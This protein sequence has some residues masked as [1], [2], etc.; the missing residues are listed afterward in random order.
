MK[1]RT[2]RKI[3]G[4]KKQQLGGVLGED[5]LKKLNLLYPPYRSAYTTIFNG[6]EEELIKELVAYGFTGET[7][8]TEIEDR[9]NEVAEELMK[10][11]N[12]P[13]NEK[14]KK[15]TSSELFDFITLY[16]N[17]PGVPVFQ[18]QLF[19]DYD[20][21]NLGELEDTEGKV[22]ISRELSRPMYDYDGTGKLDGMY[23]R[24]YGFASSDSLA[25]IGQVNQ[26]IKDALGG[27][28]GAARTVEELS[29]VLGKIFG[30]E[31]KE[32]DYKKYGTAD[33]GDDEAM[34]T[35]LTHKVQEL[36]DLGKLFG[37]AEARLTLEKIEQ[38]K[39]DYG[40]SAEDDHAAIT[41]VNRQ[42]KSLLG[43]QA[44][45]ARNVKQLSDKL[46]GLIGAG[47]KTEE[48]KEYRT[49]NSPQ[50]VKLKEIIQER[51]KEEERQREEEQRQQQQQQAQKLSADIQKLL[52]EIAAIVGF[53]ITSGYIGGTNFIS[54]IQNY[55]FGK[56][57][58]LK[59]QSKKPT[60]EYRDELTTLKGAIEAR[61]ADVKVAYGID[62]VTT[63]SDL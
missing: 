2:N 22:I 31:Y 28:E 4:K 37:I 8:A 45:D 30:P 15:L 5:D 50:N 57:P 36:K 40:F 35:V 48:Y 53:E 63:T 20:L 39:G 51:K 44:G 11:I 59:S 18:R 26:Q 27:L 62:G 23:I 56:D 19:K 49:E 13:G 1:V 7:T 12:V 21:K 38:S 3:G 32:K 6:G 14:L 54:E 16:K 25:S 47:Y 17:A 42:I 55:G 10:S 43:E 34:L 60:T 41:Q 46:Q 9:N 52:N 33:G 24:L 29:D 58:A 61:N